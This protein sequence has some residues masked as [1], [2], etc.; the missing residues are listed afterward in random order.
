MLDVFDDE[1]PDEDDVVSDDLVV[2]ESDVVS[3]E[4]SDLELFFEEPDRTSL[5]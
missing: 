4:L 5:R 3:L 2:F 1:D